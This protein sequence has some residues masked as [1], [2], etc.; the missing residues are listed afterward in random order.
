LDVSNTLF[1][2][3]LD[4]SIFQPL[5]KLLYLELGGNVYNSTLPQ[6]IVQLPH[7]EALYIYDVGLEGDLEFISDLGHMYELW[8]DDNPL[9]VG[10]LPSEIGALTSLAS[11][12]LS[13]C[14]LSGQIPSQIGALT[15]M[16]QMWLFGNWLSGTV[17]SE[18]GNLDVL[19]IFAIED[20]NITDVVMPTEIC[21]LGL[22]SLS[23]DCN[24]DW[25]F[26]CDCCTCCDEHCPVATLPLYSSRNDPSR[27][28]L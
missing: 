21:D 23:A 28:L 3:E 15:Q 2:G 22:F 5:Q 1:Y 12:S 13:N 17:P 7:L 6:E 27:F 24:E 14:D 26:S 18:I 9:I 20:N 4:G 10:T 8:M 25:G 11:L 16:E 19:Q